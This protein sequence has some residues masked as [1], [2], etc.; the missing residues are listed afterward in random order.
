ME[1][2]LCFLARHREEGAGF[3]DLRGWITR[4]VAD[5]FSPQVGKPVSGLGFGK[6]LALNT[7]LTL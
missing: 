4:Q 6:D 1:I 2:F 3:K 5:E 7:V